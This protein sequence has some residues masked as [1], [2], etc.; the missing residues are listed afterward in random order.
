MSGQGE[1]TEEL[2]T[3]GLTLV[4]QLV[5]DVPNARE[6][7][8]LSRVIWYATA[9]RA[10]EARATVE[11]EIGRA[12]SL[13][14][15]IGPWLSTR[16]HHAM[17]DGRLRAAIADAGAALVRFAEVDVASMRPMTLGVEAISL[18]QLGQSHAAR[19]V[20]DS[21]EDA[22]RHETKAQVLMEQAA[23]WL[24]VSEG[25]HQEGARRCGRA[26]KVALDGQHAVFAMCA[27]HDAARIG[28]PSLALAVLRETAQLVEGR[29]VQALLEHALALDQGDARELLALADELPTLGFTVSGA[30]CAAT[31]ARL[32]RRAGRSTDAAHADA[33]AAKLTGLIDDFQTPGLGTT[34]IVTGRER[35]IGELAARRRRNRE[36]AAQLG[37]SV[38]TVDNHLASLYRKLGISRRDELAQW[39]EHSD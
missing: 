20:I 4:H 36:I 6:L 34:V 7:L 31:A 23:G 38:R 22:W 30:E 1:R 12:G 28:H 14:G 13:D 3:E 2:V 16:A 15:V 17:L 8:T 18:A 33:V 27:A 35:Q 24:L 21:V 9:G 10:S 37:I 5:D 29:L 32:L 39:F 19:L 11:A 26:A 25:R